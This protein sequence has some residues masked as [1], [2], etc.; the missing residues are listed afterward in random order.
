MHKYKTP[1]SNITRDKQWLLAELDMAE[2]LY[3]KV[4][5]ETEAT[6]TEELQV[7]MIPSPD[8]FLLDAERYIEVWDNHTD[9]LLKEFAETWA[10]SL[11][12]ERLE[13]ER[14]LEKYTLPEDEY[15][16]K[17]VAEL[18]SGIVPYKI[19][20]AFYEARKALDTMMKCTFSSYMSLLCGLYKIMK[21]EFVEELEKLMCGLY[22]IM[23]R[24]FVEKFD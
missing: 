24:E 20:E 1:L 4:V 9:K 10:E 15:T 14:K 23:K 17:R 13:K 6:P 22:E 5:S 21:H 19:P 8:D 2:A 16:A 3:E 12:A 18:E 11:E 7:E